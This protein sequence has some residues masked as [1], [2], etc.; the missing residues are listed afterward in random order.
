MDDLLK[1]IDIIRERL[2]VSYREAKEAL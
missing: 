2:D 1:K